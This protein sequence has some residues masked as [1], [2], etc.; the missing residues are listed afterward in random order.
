[1]ARFGNSGSSRTAAPNQLPTS[2]IDSVTVP[3]RASCLDVDFDAGMQDAGPAGLGLSRS[4]AASRSLKRST[5]FPI[6][7]GC[8]I[9]LRAQGT[10]DQEAGPDKRPLNPPYIAR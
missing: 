6:G 3:F 1:M 10:P 4:A 2:S 5:V 9:G 7:L 8:E